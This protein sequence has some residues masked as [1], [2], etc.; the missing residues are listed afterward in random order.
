MNSMGKES[1][2]GLIALSNMHTS[3]S[4]HCSVLEIYR[5]SITT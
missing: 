4:T 2:R 1:P 3:W 5:K